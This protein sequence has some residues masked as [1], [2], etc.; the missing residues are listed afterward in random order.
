MAVSFDLTEPHT[1]CQPKSSHCA[2]E[3][4]HTYRASSDETT[5]FGNK[6]EMA[7]RL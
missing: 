3:C 7:S 1:D 2:R 5:Q 4:I 6:Q